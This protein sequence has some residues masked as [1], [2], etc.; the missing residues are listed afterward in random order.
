LAVHE[1]NQ[2]WIGHKNGR[3]DADARKSLLPVGCN[4]RV[5]AQGA[6]PL[7]RYSTLLRQL[8][9]G[10]LLLLGLL[11]PLDAQAQLRGLGLP[12]P[13]LGNVGGGIGAV[14]NITTA[15]RPDLNPLGNAGGGIGTVPNITTVPRPDLNPLGRV[16][17]R[18]LPNP[19]LSG[20]SQ[21]NLNLP[22]AVDAVPGRVNSTVTNT[23][24]GDVT[25]TITNGV[26]S[27][28]IDPVRGTADR[29]RDNV[30]AARNLGQPLR[31]RVPP[32]GERR[33]VR[34][35]VLVGLPT[36]LSPQA[37]DTLAR[38]HRLTRL[39]SQSIGLTGTTFHRWQI[40]DQR[41]VSE[42]VRAL[43]ADG[44]V[45]VAQPNYRFT[46]QQG[47]RPG[48]PVA[49]PE[50]QYA[51][52]KLRLPEAH[53]LATGGNVLVGVIDSGIDTTHPELAGLIAG[54][55]D[56]VGGGEPPSHHGT[57][58][59]GAI[60]AHF[61]L[62]GTAPTA[63]ILAIRAFSSTGGGDEA[64]T[65]TV[66]KGLDWAVA[67]GARIINMSFAGP[68]D[69]EIE[70]SLANA[71]RKGVILIAAAGNA[72]AKSPPLY[73]AADPNVI[74]VTATD[75]QD[76]LFVLA[77]RGRHIAVAA[78]GVDVLVP[79][80]AGAYQMST[81]TSVA[82]A[83]VSGIAALLIQLKPKLTPQAV[84]DILIATAKDLGPK[85][86]DDQFGAGLADA[87]RA[88]QSLV[89]TART[90]AASVSAAR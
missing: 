36:N 2:R 59:A 88:A 1:S 9:P 38:Q 66:L 43:E 84:R 67:H 86:R 81:G 53:R 87:Y 49:A 25:G 45:R 72:G 29:L 27:R 11:A 32:P 79:A 8:A 74:A 60:V 56:A 12:S 75:S 42:V 6:H 85:G 39:D 44:G 40:A 70:R 22:G 3:I 31:S 65:L 89:A 69:P 61:R 52:A 47:L 51:L 16:D 35:E 15:P 90:P 76:Q 13:G 78:P 62:I 20:S 24:N 55:F 26:G 80:P 73:P 17:D 48:A 82:A 58:M 54:S 33:F 18:S 7:P 37:L 21:P 5:L 23:L 57:G 46:L 10:V 68:R 4:R 28:L 41:S 50:T 64:T 34:N 14:P 30:P 19:N 63:R 71:A 83:Q 77:N